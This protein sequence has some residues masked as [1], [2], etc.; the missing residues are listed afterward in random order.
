MAEQKLPYRILLIEGASNTGKT[1]LLNELFKLAQ[2]IDLC[3]VILDVKGCP[4]LSELLDLLGFDVGS[5]VLPSFHSASGS[6]RKLALLQDLKNLKIPLLIVLD[7]YQLIAPDIAEW[8][9]GQLLRRITQCSGLLVL[10]AGQTVPDRTRY[11]WNDQAMS[12][13]LQPISDIQNWREYVNRVLHNPHI[14]EAHI[15]MLIHMTKGDPGQTSA[16]LQ[17]FSGKKDN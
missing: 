11:P 16:L 2:S 1:I 9:E 13:H 5:N 3:S 6:A 4:N 14:T 15:E 8:L 17:S 7:T 10:I 12:L